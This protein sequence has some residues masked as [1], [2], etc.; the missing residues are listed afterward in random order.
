MQVLLDSDDGESD[1]ATLVLQPGR[2]DSFEVGG[3]GSG[4]ISIRVPLYT[5]QAREVIEVLTP[6]AERKE[7]D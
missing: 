5:Y 4:G 2:D 6:L 1:F 7:L 3:Y